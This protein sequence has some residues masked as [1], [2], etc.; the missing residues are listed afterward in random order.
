MTWLIN[1]LPWLEAN[2]DWLRINSFSNS[3]TCSCNCK[4]RCSI[5][6]GLAFRICAALNTCA[7]SFCIRDKLCWPVTAS[8]RRMPAATPLSEQILNNP[9]SPVLVTCVPPHNSFE[10][11]I[12]KTRTDSPYFSPKSIIAPVFWACSNDITCAVVAW[13]LSISELT[14]SSTRNISSRETGAV[15]AKSKRVL[16]AS[17]KDPLCWTWEPKT[18]RKALCMRCVALWLRIIACRFVIST[19]AD[20]RSLTRMVPSSKMPWWPKT[21]AWIFKVSSTKKNVCALRISPQSPTCPP[22]SA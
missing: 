21:S 2:L 6:S 3:R 13:L 16:L 7:S 8:I 22:D 1:S 18:S 11:P 19:L 5:S 12:S 10:D 4:T 20:S 9:M 14:S 17:T 15:W